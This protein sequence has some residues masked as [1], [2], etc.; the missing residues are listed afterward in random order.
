MPIDLITSG[1]LRVGINPEGG[2]DPQLN[3]ANNLLN[4]AGNGAAAEAWLINYSNS[5]GGFNFRL[6]Q[7]RGTAT[8]PVILQ[9]GDYVFELEAFA[10]NGVNFMEGAELKVTVDTATGGPI[11]PGQ[12]IPTRMEFWTNIVNT[13]PAIKAFIT[14]FG[15]LE[16]F[17]PAAGGSGFRL[18]H[19]IAPAAGIANGDLWTTTA[20]LFGR[21]NGTTQQ[22][23]PLASPTFTGTVTVAALTATGLVTFQGG[24]AASGASSNDFSGGSGTFKTSTG[25]NTLSGAVDVNAAVT[26]SV[27]LNSGKTNTGFLLIN[28]KTSGSLKIITADA[29]AQAVTF[30]LAGQ[31]VGAA[32]LTF[33]DLVGVAKTVPYLE[34]AQTFTAIQTFSNTIT[35]SA[36]PGF[37][38]TDT[39]GAGADQ[40]GITISA[41]NA[42]DPAR[43]AVLRLR[44]FDNGFTGTAE[45]FAAS[46]G[47]IDLLI[48]S[49]SK[50]KIA[51][52]GLSAFNDT[53]DATSTSN[54]SVVFKGGISA[55]K[56]LCL[57]GA[58]GKTLRIVNAVANAAV[59]VTLGSTG[60]TGS[61]AGAPQGWMRIDING[62]DRYMPFW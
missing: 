51:S 52:T 48:G 12:A 60:P 44:G 3:S 28:G 10:Y 29:T 35:F 54:G 43:G 55:Q 41:T 21:I 30:I 6:G 2:A 31:T 62:T 16:T 23:A 20:G 7:A 22:Y 1:R 39:T 13:V 47:Y 58:T 38:G 27:T 4:V 56:R 25:A 61:T 42:D 26:P 15:T 14:A 59:A 11:V 18:P 36:S 37:I 45:I 53:T 33:P 17:T 50:F 8:A 46:N 40:K 9:N 5:P 19:G 57:D 24:I 49:T 32:T 34:R